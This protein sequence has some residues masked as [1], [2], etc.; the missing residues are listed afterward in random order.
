MVLVSFFDRMVR[1][2]KFSHMHFIGLQFKLAELRKLC[3]LQKNIQYEQK[4]KF[5]YNNEQQG[6]NVKS[7]EFSFVSSCLRTSI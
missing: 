7:G 2:T 3:S 1:K 4:N 6:I 5:L